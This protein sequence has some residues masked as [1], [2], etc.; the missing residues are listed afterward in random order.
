MSDENWVT[1]VPPEVLLANKVLAVCLATTSVTTAWTLPLFDRAFDKEPELRNRLFCLLVGG[2]LDS[3][4]EYRNRIN[5]LKVDARKV[6]LLAA[7]F[8]LD[9]FEKYIALAVDMLEMF[10]RDEMIMLTDCRDQWLHGHWTEVHKENRT[11]YYAE[12]GSII[13]KKVSSVEYNKTLQKMFGPGVDQALL[14]MR[15]RFCAYRTFFW[16]IDRTL[17]APKVRDAIQKGS[18]IARSISEAGCGLS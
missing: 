2:L 6:R 13:K 17:S 18:V 7:P 10:S 16:A 1:K 9:I 5:G 4:W 11:I 14:E 12:K 15:K 8:Y 3:G